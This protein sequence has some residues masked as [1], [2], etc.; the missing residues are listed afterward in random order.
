MEGHHHLRKRT[1]VAITMVKN[2]MDIIESFV[3]HTLGF[4]DLLIVADHKSTDRTRE[5]LESLQKEGLPII[6]E[7]VAQARHVQAETMT[8]L[9]WEAADAYEA[10]LVL[11]LDADEFILPVQQGQVRQL[12][13]ALPEDYVSAIPMRHYLPRE[14]TGVRPGEFLLKQPLRRMPERSEVRKVVVGGEFVRAEH[15]RLGE[16]NHGITR[17]RGYFCGR[18]SEELEIAHFPWRSNAQYFS[19]FAVAWPN[20]VAKYSVNT[21]QGGGYRENFHRMLIGKA[22]YQYAEEYVDCSLVG[23]VPMP[24]LRYS[25]DTIPDVLANVMAASEALAEDYAETRAL[26]GKPLVTTIL[27]YPKGGHASFEK[28]QFQKTLAS[29]LEESYPWREIIVVVF[30]ESLPELWKREAERKGVRFLVRPQGLLYAVHGAY[31]EWLLPGE[32]VRAEKLRRM[33]TCLELQDDPYP[34]LVSDAGGEYPA[35]LPY[36]DFQVPAEHNIDVYQGGVAWRMLLRRGAYPSRGLA[37]VLVRRDVFRR[38]GGLMDLLAEWRPPLLRMWR[39]LLSTTVNQPC[40]W[41]AVLHDNYTGPAETLP[42]EAIAAHQME[43]RALCIED[44]ALLQESERARIIDRQRRMGIY[45][46]ERAM[47]EGQNFETG[48][49]PAYQ[50]MLAGL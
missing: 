10:D 31:V 44:A 42:I 12:L 25:D 50:Q 18:S 8:H 35:S 16:G 15:V 9:L 43:W 34:I 23:L 49:W 22:L 39:A 48:I 6:I 36:F 33:V 32:T 17:G 47:A 28:E 20:I 40:Q 37:G 38:C 11:A 26:A 27:P 1:I 2:E 30:D 46:L 5:I 13:E 29:A 41:L 45:L 21:Q 7:D 24:E 19:K 4:A 14:Q 3:R